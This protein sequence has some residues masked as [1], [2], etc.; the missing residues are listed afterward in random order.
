VELNGGKE[1]FARK[2]EYGFQNNLIDYG[3]EPAFLAVQGFHYAG[4][5]DLSSYWVR[6]LMSRRFTEKGV[7]GNDDSGAMSAWYIFSAMGFFPNAGQNIYY[8]TGPLF[9]K[10]VVH[11]GNGKTLTINAPNAS[12]TNIYVRSFAINGKRMASTI[13]SYNDIKDGGSITFDMS[14]T[15][16]IANQ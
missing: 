12:D 1:T 15:P 7:P 2:L 16:V 9:K 11:L 8:V 10:V 5:P 4:R 3:N 6:R 14:E 13:I